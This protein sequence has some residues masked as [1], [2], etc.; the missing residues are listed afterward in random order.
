MSRPV[1]NTSKGTVA[2][3]RPPAESVRRA[4]DRAAPAWIVFATFERDAPGKLTPLPRAR[5]FFRLAGCSFNYEAL[6]IQ[7]FQTLSRM[8]GE[9]DTFE[10][11]YSNLDEAVNLFSALPLP[12]PPA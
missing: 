4:G 1:R 2:H 6:G 5:A 8:I 11:R 10:F 9:C 12:A 7:G 3:M